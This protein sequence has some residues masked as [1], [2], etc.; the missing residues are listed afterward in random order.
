MSVSLVSIS[1]FFYTHL[2][3]T[4]EESSTKPAS[5]HFSSII[6]REN[7]A[8]DDKYGLL[9][10]VTAYGV[11]VEAKVKG[12]HVILQYLMDKSVSG[13][14]QT[15]VQVMHCTKAQSYSSAAACKEY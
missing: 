3:N 2:E 5:I 8:S 7:N 15:I 4:D 14:I 13:D 6:Y 11:R 10:Y 1:F 9:L 12:R